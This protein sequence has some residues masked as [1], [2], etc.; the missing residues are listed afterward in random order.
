MLVKLAQAVGVPLQILQLEP[1]QQPA[2]GSEVIVIGFGF[3]EGGTASNVL[4][5]VVGFDDYDIVYNFIDDET[6]ICAGVKEGGHV[7]CQG[8]SG[9]PLFDSNGAQVGV[10]GCARLGIPG[11]V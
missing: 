9:G 4:L 3:T 10:V 5:E 7:N 1:N 11:K 2:D 8:D 6:M